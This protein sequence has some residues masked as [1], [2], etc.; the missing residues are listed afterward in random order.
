MN[1]VSTSRVRGWITGLPLPLGVI[2]LAIV[3]YV[4]LLLT[5]PGMV[6]A[7]TKTYLYLN[8]GRLLSRAPY[9]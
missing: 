2:L 3:S 6:G 4:P 9:M 1:T 7:D 5:K 8:P